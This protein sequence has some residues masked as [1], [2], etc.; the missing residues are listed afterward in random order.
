MVDGQ[1]GDATISFGCVDGTFRGDRLLC[2]C[3]PDS[4]EGAVNIAEPTDREDD[5]GGKDAED[6][7]HSESEEIAPS[8][9]SCVPIA[10]AP[11]STVV[12][13]SPPGPRGQIGS[14]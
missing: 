6:I 10:Y 3:L 2:R 12:R 9:E 11:S 1:Y 14:S 4:G 13:P 7:Q 8:Q 5:A